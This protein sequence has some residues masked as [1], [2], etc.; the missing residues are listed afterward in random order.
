[1]KNFNP[2]KLKMR[3]GAKERIYS[4]GNPL[5]MIKSYKTGTDQGSMSFKSNAS[6]KDIV[7]DE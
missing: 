6:T 2:S 1:M 5:R 7:N 3:E 4:S